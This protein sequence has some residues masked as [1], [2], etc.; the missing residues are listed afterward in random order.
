MAITFTMTPEQVRN[1]ARDKE[2]A[3]Q[4]QQVA[5]DDYSGARC[6]LINGPLVGLILAAQAVEKYL[7]AIILL[8]KPNY[9]LKRLRHALS[10]AVTEA[11]HLEPS[12]D[13]SV[14]S[15]TISILEQHYN[16]RYPDNANQSSKKGTNELTGIDNLMIYIV[17]HI[18]F[19]VDIK[20]RTGLYAC[21]CSSRERKGPPFPDEIWITCNNT[22]LAPILSRIYEGHAAQ[23][24][25]W[26]TM[27]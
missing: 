16:S 5:T 20:H 6:C 22:A 7:K 15:P 24:D 23:L 17:E 4:Y 8:R 11:S 18:P 21:V 1:Y 14:Y 9:N 3:L 27:K 19:P 12:I 10:D 2:P 25:L 13:L 26:K